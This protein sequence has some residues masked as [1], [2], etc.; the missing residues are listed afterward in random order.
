MI[1]EKLKV[2]FQKL[3]RITRKAPEVSYDFEVD[4]IHRIVARNIGSENAFYTSNCSDF[5]PDIEEFIDA[6]LVENV[7]DKSNLSI[8][9][10]EEFMEALSAD[11]DWNL[12]F[13]DTTFEKYDKE[14]NGDITVWESKNYPVIIH[15]TVKAKYLWNK[16]MLSTYNRNDPGVLFL[17][18]ANKLNPLAYAE[19]LRSS[20]PCVAGDTLVDCKIQLTDI[21]N[22]SEDDINKLLVDCKTMKGY[23]TTELTRSNDIFA[24]SINIKDLTALYKLGADIAV[25]S[26]DIKIDKSELEYK[27]VSFADKTRENANII[28][29]ELEDGKVLKLTPD[30]KVYTTNR[31]Y[32]EACN[33]NEDDDV[34]IK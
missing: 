4:S 8:G 17:G 11:A 19:R 16:I 23:N 6:K 20:N 18:L 14:W 28:E 26:K 29:L 32:I 27:E 9:I 1:K 3:V 7:L 22:G 12:R 33:L 25:M 5:H 10:S 30:H 15:K 2:K 34:V 24:G 31:G 21:F 13:P